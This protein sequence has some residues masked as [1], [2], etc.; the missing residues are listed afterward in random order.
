MG[1]NILVYFDLLF[2]NTFCPIAKKTNTQDKNGMWR[3]VRLFFLC[4][5]SNYGSISNEPGSFVL[6]FA[7][8]F[9]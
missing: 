9:S 3:A 4:E 2:L 8:F 1:G 5:N 6:F 7:S